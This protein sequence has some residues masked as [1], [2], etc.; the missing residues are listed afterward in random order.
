MVPIFT[1]RLVPIFTLNGTDLYLNRYRKGKLA[2]NLI[3]KLR[4]LHIKN[5]NR[6]CQQ[7]GQSLAQTK[8]YFL[9]CIM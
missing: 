4:E 7:S 3:K 9:N 1:G 2:T 5:V 6:N 8:Y